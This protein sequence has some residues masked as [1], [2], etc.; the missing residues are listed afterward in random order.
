MTKAKTATKP[1]LEQN[2]DRLV[3]AEKDL[4]RII[5]HAT[6]TFCRLVD[7]DQPVLDRLLGWAKRNVDCA[8]YAPQVKDSTWSVEQTERFNLADELKNWIETVTESDND[9]KFIPLL[10]TCFVSIGIGLV[11]WDEVARHYLTKYRESIPTK[12]LTNVMD[13][14]RKTP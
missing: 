14:R 7:S 8:P 4:N 13:R 1:T 9:D 3:R 10:A 6:E 12:P 11:N 5:D 2:L